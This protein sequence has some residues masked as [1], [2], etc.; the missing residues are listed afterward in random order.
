MCVHLEIVNRSRRRLKIDDV[1]QASPVHFGCG[2]WGL[3][4]SGLL[5]TKE[6]YG[7]VYNYGVFFDRGRESTC[8]GCELRDNT[9]KIQFDRFTSLYRP[10][11]YS[12]T[13]DSEGLTRY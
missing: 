9:A 8:C 3:M 5:S 6:N 10:D 1:V 13:I 4:A 12:V 11:D 2:V 7:A